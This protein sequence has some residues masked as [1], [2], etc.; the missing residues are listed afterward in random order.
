M[1]KS[2]GGWTLS[3]LARLLGGEFEGPADLIIRRPVPAGA[4]DPEGIAF[5]ESEE[6]FH[7]VEASHVGAVILGPGDRC[8]KPCIRVERPREAFRRL[9]QLCD[10]PMPLQGGVH[11]TAVVS[12]DATIH[13]TASIGPYAVVEQ[14]AIIGAGVRIFPFCYVGEDCKIGDETVIYP[15]ASLYKNVSVGKR[16][17]IHS[18]AVLGADGFGFVWD[19]EKQQKVPQIGAVVVGDDVEFGAN[20]AADRATMGS[21]VVEGGVKIDNLVQLGHNTSVGEHS[22]IAGQTGIGGSTRIGKRVTMAG[23]VAVPDHRE[24]ADDV[25]LAGRSAVLDDIKEPGTYIGAPA[26]KFGEGMK[27]LALQLKLPDMLS[28]LRKVESKLKKLGGDDE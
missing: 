18:G 4:D 14:G 27:I 15:H 17:I 2:T 3:E 8:Q 21:T 6:Y 11:P 23:Q 25:T 26:L 22:V 10:R 16:C 19:G 12:P 24:I 13:E 1:A 9:L 28:R 7:K 20:S 5:A